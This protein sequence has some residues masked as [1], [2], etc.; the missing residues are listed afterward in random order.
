MERVEL[1]EPSTD[2]DTAPAAIRPGDPRSA[3]DAAAIDAFDDRMALPLVAAA[4]L[5]LFL[6]PGSAWPLL[7]AA[8]SIVSWLVFLVDLVVHQRRKFRYLHTWMGRFDLSVV[9]LTAP[10][11][12]ILG[13]GNSKFVLLIRLARLARLVMAG[14]GARRLLQ[15]VGRVALVALSVVL[16]GAAAAYA[17]EHPTNPEFDTYGDS[18]WWSAVTLTTVG[19]GD[20]VP[21]TRGGRIVGGAIMVTGIG[22]LGVLAGSLASFFEGGSSDPDAEDEPDATEAG[23]APPDPA[24]GTELVAVDASELRALREE[25]AAVRVQ[26]AA[27]AGAS[28]DP[29]GP[30]LD[31]SS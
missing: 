26:L 25:L 13:D 15:R 11:F 9:I 2:D 12:L 16:L 10:W 30:P 24:P 17:A 6:L 3:E 8:V 29:P 14:K 21:I 19:Y 31:Q 5:P 1:D 27:L 4:V 18:V 22:V 7:S 20:I 23:A 28:A